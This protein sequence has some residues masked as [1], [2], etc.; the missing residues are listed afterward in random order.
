M[1]MEIICAPVDDSRRSYCTTAPRRK[2]CGILPICRGR[3][4][5]SSGKHGCVA[6]YWTIRKNSSAMPFR[7]YLAVSFLSDGCIPCATGVGFDTTMDDSA[8]TAQGAHERHVYAEC[9]MH[10]LHTG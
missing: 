4:A 5:L 10:D 2:E 3:N 8:K 7:Q 6:K 9:V 1:S